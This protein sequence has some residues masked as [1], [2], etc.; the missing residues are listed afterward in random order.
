M[1]VFYTIILYLIT[2]LTISI[3]SLTNN[4]YNRLI[5]SSENCEYY[6][7]EKNME[8][9]L[10]TYKNADIYKKT[11]I[12]DFVRDCVS[13]E[14]LTN[15]KVFSIYINLP[16]FLS[17]QTYPYSLYDFPEI[18]NKDY[19]RSVIELDKSLSYYFNKNSFFQNHS[20][21][22]KD[23]YSYWKPV[24]EEQLKVKLVEPEIVMY[25][26]YKNRK[27]YNRAIF[28]FITGL[29][30]LFIYKKKIRKHNYV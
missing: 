21:T 28:I 5:F 3:L 27:Y 8:Y 24:V 4:F 7:N 6:N 1:I 29:L 22:I 10:I 9:L 13:T 11:Y 23:F 2:G 17:E 26:K 25:D 16:F 12:T 18:N 15:R 20:F 19:G 30:F 14:Y